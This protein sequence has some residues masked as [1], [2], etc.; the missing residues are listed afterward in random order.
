MSSIVNLNPKIRVLCGEGRLK[1]AIDILLTTHNTAVESS[2]YL[3]LLNSCVSKKALA[4]GKQIHSHING[5]GITFSTN[6]FLQNAVINM[7]DK[8]GSLVDACQVFEKMTAPDVFSWN[9]MIAAHRRHGFPQQAL[10]LFHQMQPTAVQPDQFT[11]SAVI[12]VCASMLSVNHGLQIHGKIIRYGLQSNVIVMNTLI[13]MYAKC[14]SIEKSREVFEKMNNANVISWTAM[15][16]GYAHNGILDEALRIF[17]EMPGQD[18]V[19]WTAIIAGYAQNGLV[20]KALELYKEMQLEG[21]KPNSATF[22]SMLPA[23]AKM[24]DLKHGMEIHQ[25]IIENGF[26][27]DVVVVTALVDMYVK[28][29]SLR[30]AH[31]L[32]EKMRLRNAVSWNT[33]I[34]GYAKMGFAEIAWQ[35]LNQMQLVGIKPDS[36]TFASVLPSCAKIGALE[37]GM[38][39]HQ[40]ITEMGFFS[41]VT[42]VNSLIDMYAKCG[43]IQ[44]AYKLFIGMS[45]RNVVSWNTMVFGYVQNGL[46]EKALEIF[47]RM[48]I[49]G[50]KLDLSTFS[51]ILP[52]C[53]RLGALEQGMKIHQKVFKSGLMPDDVVTTALIDMYAKCGSM[54]KA[55][56]LFNKM[57]QQD[58]ISL[59]AIAAGYVQNGLVEKAVDIF[60]QM[61][62]AGVKPDS[63]MFAS[64]LPAFAKLG[65]LE[66]GMEIHQKIIESMFLSDIVVVN[67]LIDMYAKCGSI[68]KA[69]DL[70][71]NIDHP[72]VA[73]W[74]AMISGYAMHGYSEDASKLFEL[75][76]RSGVELDHVSFVGI[77]FACSHAGLVDEGCTYFNH[78]RYTYCILPSMDHYVCM[79]DLLGRADYLEEALNFTI[80]MPIK[81]DPVVWVCLLGAC[82]SHKN[83]GLG[84]FVAILLLEL[85]LKNAAPYVLLSNI[86]AEV[87]RWADVQKVRKLM[88]NTGNKKTPG[89]SW[90]EVH[91]TINVFSVGDKSHPQI[92]EI[93]AKLEKLSWEMKAAGYVMDTRPVLNDVEDEEK[94]LILC[95]HSE[96]LAIAFGLLNTSP[97]TT[98]KIVKNLRV[99]GDCHT[100]T[101]IIS[102]IVEREIVV[103]DANRF[104]HFKHGKCSCGD[105]W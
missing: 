97:G 24:G 29:G 71:D 52:A 11:F 61:Q 34:A 38:E 73:S 90:I 59:T 83:L 66:R 89:C 98:I 82:R 95:H 48:Q 26:V 68:Q 27:L 9:V 8:C 51:S 32:F 84:E 3:H 92:Q 7:Y 55:C 31:N 42:V 35:M 75:M 36:S 64:I 23:C 88:K 14:G 22:T 37:Q 12:P 104:H 39:I 77:L 18:V 5:R 53:A 91:K 44:K 43:K 1:E 96:K 54:Q 21:V 86:Y 101:K 4:E 41:D 15:I 94:E 46:V 102:K 93:Y 49:S 81:P 50:M 19:S 79:V 17:K 80:K 76:R 65:A 6:T 87:G 30:K 25:T 13:D 70:F 100:A 10:K 47:K 63:S 40:K 105:Y 62:L 56:Q 58:V 60:K 103:R 78:M 28:C 20:G 74:N 2:T 69:R 45:Q 72:D 67:A 85:D 16:T 99:C 33:M 57:P